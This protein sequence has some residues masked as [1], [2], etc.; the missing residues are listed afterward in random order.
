MK[1]SGLCDPGPEVRVS[2]QSRKPSGRA[3][4]I[5]NQDEASALV[6]VGNA[7]F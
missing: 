1:R 2:C 5:R 3:T 4:K 6:R 7:R